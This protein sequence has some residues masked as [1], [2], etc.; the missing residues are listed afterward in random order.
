MLRVVLWYLASMK[1]RANHLNM[2]LVAELS[3]S[4]QVEAIM[5]KPVPRATVYQFRDACRD[6][7]TAHHMLRYNLEFAAYLPCRIALV[8]DAKG[9]GWW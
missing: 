5:G 6:A 1:L 8:E 9:Q 3:R 2:Q 4:K 7:M